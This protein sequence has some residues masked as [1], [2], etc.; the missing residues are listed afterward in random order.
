[1]GGTLNNNG[2]NLDSSI[3]IQEES[4]NPQE[5][6]QDEDSITL[7]EAAIII[8]QSMYLPALSI[9]DISQMSGGAMQITN[10]AG[11]TM[12][13]EIRGVFTTISINSPEDAALSLTSVRNI[14][15]I[16]EISYICTSVEERG[17]ARLFFLQQVY[18]GVVVYS[19]RYQVIAS[20]DGTPEAVI[21]QFTAV[22]DGINLTPTLTAA[23]ARNMAG[24]E[25]NT[26]IADSTLV[27]YRGTN[28]QT[29]LCWLLDTWD[30]L[31][32]IDAHTGEL[33]AELT[34]LLN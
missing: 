33:A 24:L 23:Q 11:T 30:K 26:A 9:D 18:G 3:V 6:Q 25:E 14:M 27:I 21:G 12:P 16:G 19:G 28:G 34:T 8:N 17:S 32:F 29:L 22:D 7:P 15:N 2:E 10:F 4:T 31:I 5:A 13:R 20:L 1:M